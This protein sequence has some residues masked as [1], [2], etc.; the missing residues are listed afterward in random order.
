[1]YGL[2]NKWKETCASLPNIIER[3]QT[4]NEL[5]QQAFQFSS[6]LSRIDG[7]QQAIKQT[8]ETNST[9]LTSLKTNL[10]KNLD[11]IKTNFD[12]LNQRLVSL[13]TTSSKA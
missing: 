4:L 13:N 2:I 5:H 12:N 1:M 6:A 11:S 9:L 3:L 8:L 7:D 10:D